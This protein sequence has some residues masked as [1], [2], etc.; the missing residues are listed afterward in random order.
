MKKVLTSPISVLIAHILA[1]AANFAYSVSSRTSPLKWLFLAVTMLYIG[2]WLLYIAK[3]RYP[4]VATV[5]FS[6]MLAVSVV[7]FIIAKFALLAD[8]FIIPAALL[9]VPFAGFEA[10]VKPTYCWLII[11]AVSVIMI[12]FSL[13]KKNEYW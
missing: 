1:F 12:V 3:G 5:V 4:K 8:W 2:V 11:A 10:I 7:G 9:V 13:R 6:V